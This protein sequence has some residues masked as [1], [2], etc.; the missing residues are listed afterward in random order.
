[1]HEEIQQPPSLKKNKRR[2]GI[3]STSASTSN[4]PSMP[5]SF[6]TEQLPHY[7]QNQT[8]V[9]PTHVVPPLPRNPSAEKLKGVKTEPRKK[10]E[11][12][13]AFRSLD[14]DLR[15]HDSPL[16]SMPRFPANR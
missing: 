3:F 1:M 5:K 13:N 4:L 7:P 11:L 14:A 15:K 16:P 6:S 9:S 12:W 2:S 8:P 10:D